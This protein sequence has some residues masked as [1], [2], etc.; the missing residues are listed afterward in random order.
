[1][2]ESTKK[3][4]W[5]CHVRELR[6]SCPA[7]AVSDDSADYRKYGVISFTKSEDSKKP[8]NK[9]KKQKVSQRQGRRA[10]NSSE[11]RVPQRHLFRSHRSYPLARGVERWSQKVLWPGARLV[12]SRFIPV[13]KPWRAILTIVCYGIEPQDMGA[14][15]ECDL[16]ANTHLEE[17][18]LVSRIPDRQLTAAPT[19]RIMSTRR[20]HHIHQGQKEATCR[21]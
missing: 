10:D 21:V 19:L 17:A 11:I 6:V 15:W 14:D 16:C 9:A 13:S 1:M 20:L 3:Y 7:L 5:G 2:V 8:E 12:L 4:T 18:H